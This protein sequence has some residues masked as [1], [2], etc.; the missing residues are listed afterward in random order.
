VYVYV[1]TVIKNYIMEY[2][3]YQVKYIDN[4]LPDSRPLDIPSGEI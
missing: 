3:D 2:S 4:V 1:L